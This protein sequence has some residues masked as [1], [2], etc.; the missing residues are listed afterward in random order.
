[1][2]DYYTFKDEFVS[3]CSKALAGTAFAADGS[4]I[5]GIQ[6]E[7]KPVTKAQ[8]GQLTGLIFKAEDNNCAPTYYMEDIYGMYL[9]GRSLDELAHGIVQSACTMVTNPPE[10]ADEDAGFIEDPANL[11]IRLLNRS[12]NSAF[13]E[14]I[15]SLDVGCGLVM[16]AEMRS[17]EYSAAV[18]ADLMEMLGLT[19]EELFER[20]M[21]NSAMSDKAT[22]FEISDVLENGHGQCSNLLDPRE[23]VFNA[24]VTPGSLYVLSNSRQYQGASVLFY[25]GMLDRLYSIMG[26]DF[27]ILPSSVHEVLLLPLSEDDAGKLTG[28]IRSANR[29]VVSDAD[30]LSDDL[31]VCRSGKLQSIST[32]MGN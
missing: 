17:G 13:L 15:P 32:V 30:F 6:I 27:Y 22:L 4:P 1:M 2:L 23:V 26:G 3:C 9:E 16:T 18:T 11:R 21:E 29:E 20:A 19:K 28:I 8:F 24:P 10:L 7:E 14:R 12:R 31:I 5:A 25:P